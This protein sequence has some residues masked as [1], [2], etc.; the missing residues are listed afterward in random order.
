MTE[1]FSIDYLIIGAGF[2]GLYAADKLSDLGANVLV[3]EKD[4]ESF[5]RASFVNQARI[6]NGYHYPRS[7]ATAKKTKEYYERFHEEFGFCVN[8]SF[9]KIYAISKNFSLTSPDQFENFCE[10]A[11]IPYEEI[12]VGKYFN[13]NEV[14]KAYTSQETTYDAKILSQEL[15]K[16][17]QRKKVP[18]LFSEE[19]IQAE[20]K[21]GNYMVE[22]SSGKKFLTPRVLNATY[23]GLNQLN[24]IF[25]LET[26]KIKYELCEVVLV[27]AESE[28][29]KLGL[30]LMDGP[31]ISIMPFGKTGYHSLTAVTYTPIRQSSTEL[32]NFPCQEKEPGCSQFSLGNCDTCP[33]KPTSLY[34]Y[35]DQMSK[36]YLSE[37]MTY[38]Y[39]KSLFTVKTVL[40]ASEMDDSR[41]TVIR[42]K[43]KTP[44]F[45]SVL[46]GKINTVF[47]LEED[48]KRDLQN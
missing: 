41:P 8:D 37:R 1:S 47:D 45:R 2:Y 4:P 25:A 32:P 48:L 19:V 35:M 12:R 43:N 14:L 3:L 24:R 13:E 23:A 46:S 10:A 11:E 21:E 33:S 17:L 26:E 27:R 38:K 18:I 42:A 29:K 31:F 5:M 6:H 36:K 20:I 30:T 40:L 9:H 39:V 34:P 22:T 44:L 16:R 7:L 15:V 28:L